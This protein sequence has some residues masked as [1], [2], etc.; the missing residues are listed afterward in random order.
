MWKQ[1]IKL[2]LPFSDAMGC[3]RVLGSDPASWNL[4]DYLSN[5]FKQNYIKLCSFQCIPPL[6][7][8][9]TKPAVN[10]ELNLKCTANVQATE[11]RVDFQLER[12]IA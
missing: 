6:L 10:Q 5:C 1:I 3:F 9:D 11:P 12:G 8:K 4:L 7:T 2:L